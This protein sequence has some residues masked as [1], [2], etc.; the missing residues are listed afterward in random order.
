M[1]P[2]HQ[3]AALAREHGL[4]VTIHDRHP[5][6]DNRYDLLHSVTD[7]HLRDAQASLDRGELLPLVGDDAG[8]IGYVIDGPPLTDLMRHLNGNTGT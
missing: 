1:N 2:T 6:D 7:G 5:E 8:I 4:R 3:I